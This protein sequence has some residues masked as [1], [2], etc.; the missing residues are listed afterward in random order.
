[1]SK[2]HEALRELGERSPEPHANGVGGGV[3]CRRDLVVALLV[4]RSSHHDL[5]V[6]GGEQLEGEPN[7]GLDLTADRRLRRGRRATR[8][9]EDDRIGGERRLPRHV[10]PLGREVAVTVADRVLDDDEEE[11][12]ELLLRLDHHFGPVAK[13]A[14]QR[15]LHEVTGVGLAPQGGPE[16]VVYL[17]LE[18]VEVADDELVERSIVALRVACE[19]ASGRLGVRSS[20][21]L[22]HVAMSSFPVAAASPS[23]PAGG[24][25]D[26]TKILFGSRRALALE[27]WKPLSKQGKDGGLN[28]LAPEPVDADSEIETWVEQYLAQLQAGRV[29]RDVFL[30]QCPASIRE[31][32][33]EHLQALGDIT[34]VL[35]G[36][37]TISGADDPALDESGPRPGRPFGDFEIVRELGRGGMGVVYLARQRSLG[38]LVAL[39]VLNARASASPRHLS[40]FRREAEAIARLNHPGIVAIHAVGQEGDEAYLVME[41]IEGT[42]LALELQR[43]GLSEAKARRAGDTGGK[44]EA[45]ADDGSSMMRSPVAIPPHAPE[46][47]SRAASGDKS[48]VA[49]ATHAFVPKTASSPAAPSTIASPAPPAERGRPTEGLRSHEHCRWAAEVAAEVAEALAYAHERGVIH[50]DIKPANILLDHRGRARIVDFGLAKSEDEVGLSMSG[51]VLGTYHYMSPEQTECVPGNLDRRT[52]VFSLGVVLYQMLSGQLP[53]TGLTGVQIVRCIQETDPIDVRVLNPEV[54]R[55][56]ETICARALEKSPTRRYASA[57]EFAADLRR[58]LSHQA[59]HAR[60][61]SAG[62]NAMRWITRRRRTI[63]IGA[64]L[65]VAIVTAVWGTRSHLRRSAVQELLAPIEAFVAV[66]RSERVELET[67]LAVQRNRREIEVRFP[68]FVPRSEALFARAEHEI[69]AR[70]VRRRDEAL[71]VLDRASLLVGTTA[72]A[73]AVSGLSPAVKSLLEAQ[74]LTPDDPV[75]A[76]LEFEDPELALVD[77]PPDAELWILSRDPFSSEVLAREAVEVPASGRLTLSP[78]YYRFE[79]R[80]GDRFAE[81]TRHLRWGQTCEIRVQLRETTEVVADMGWVPAGEFT[82][83]TE[84]PHHPSLAA[85][86]ID[87]PGFYIDTHEVTVAE[88]A[89]FLTATGYPPPEHEDWAR[90]DATWDD[91]P[92]TFVTWHD[93]RAY[94]EWR[95]KRLPT[96]Y[97]WEKAARS[98]DARPFPWGSEPP[99]TE[100]ARVG[101]PWGNRDPLD[102]FRGSAPVGSSP[103]DRSPYG[104]HDLYGNVAEWTESFLIEF[105]RGEF[106]FRER[107]PVLNPDWR[108]IKG[109]SWTTPIDPVYDLTGYYSTY[110]TDR[111]AYVGFRCAKTAQ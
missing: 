76:M 6:L 88:Y 93:A 61:P 80:E 16:P 102:F 63:A 44:T 1:M 38:R 87:L 41:Y 54:P 14:D 43:A 103:S 21:G 53:F 2:S 45:L 97:E 59:I 91:R 49:S 12:L 70:A 32:L 35:R 24:G 66:P 75:L 86:T 56:L 20:L 47:E 57:G 71:A 11:P 109:E 39:K 29:D 46:D 17:L 19:Q 60:P 69:R 108:I 10:P 30:D 78:G 72:R 65:V 34:R 99:S 92:V 77:F 8:V 81:Y 73:E 26:L 110:A 90:R 5:A 104:I 55:D 15:L 64:F 82:W 74:R 48:D 100:R 33:A 94:A 58:F 9:E 42:S 4:P 37:S 3:D 40:R 27:R 85:R 107:V 105:T 96:V 13:E 7:L 83:G 79:V 98:T 84:E 67:M 25:E 31:S 101:Q 62:E 89:E 52:D 36:E 50:R 51:E 18:P 22:G 95:G 23:V 68:A 106:V 111:M 28:E